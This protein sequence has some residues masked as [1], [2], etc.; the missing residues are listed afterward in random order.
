MTGPAI[1]VADA[2]S[3][4]RATGR[5]GPSLPLWIAMHED[6]KTSARFHAV[7]DALAAGLPA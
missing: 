7:F 6:L 2:W 5:I 1:Q 4:G 3:S